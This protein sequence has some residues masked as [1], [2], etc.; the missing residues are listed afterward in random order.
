VT[1]T[2]MAL[3]CEPCPQGTTGLPRYSGPQVPQSEWKAVDAL[4]PFAPLGKCQFNL[5]ACCTYT[6]VKAYQTLHAFHSGKVGNFPEVSYAAMHQEATGGRMQQG[7]RPVDVLRTAPQGLVPVSP[8]TP[9]FFTSPRNFSGKGRELLKEDEWQEVFGLEDTVS[10][11]LSLHA[12]NVC[13][14]WRQRDANPGPTG[15]L[16]MEA[17]G[18]LGGHSVLAVGIRFDYRNSP[19]GIG[20]IIQ[21]HHG[22]KLSSGGK[23]EFGLVSGVWGDNGFGIVPI[24]R[25]VAGAE[26]Y[27]STALRTVMIQDKDLAN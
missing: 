5:P 21:N 4:R 8:E 23:N 18:M 25:I 27:S 13:L 26:K 14:D 22:D 2:P 19:S 10:A 15:E 3:G 1:T 24:E 7:A 12:V 16:V 20:V 17:G 6:R 11:V 9:E